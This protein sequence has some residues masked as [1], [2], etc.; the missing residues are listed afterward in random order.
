MN[1]ITSGHL[2]DLLPQARPHI[3]AYI[4]SNRSAREILF[5]FYRIANEGTW[6]KKLS[7]GPHDP[8]IPSCWDEGHTARLLWVP[9]L[10]TFL[11][12]WW[13]SFTKKAPAS[14]QEKT[15]LRFLLHISKWFGSLVVKSRA[16]DWH[17]CFSIDTMG[18]SPEPQEAWTCEKPLMSCNLIPKRTS[19][20]TP[21]LKRN[22][23]CQ[24][25]LYPQ[26]SFPWYIK[27]LAS[28]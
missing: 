28:L 10:P 13:Y 15:H 21:S 22:S 5:L 20:Y 9:A 1:I 18:D 25:F 19:Y 2:I 6:S 27:S 16:Y 8:L 11:A 7:S 14:P 3:W 12:L 17:I 24:N 4:V 26:R 23:Q